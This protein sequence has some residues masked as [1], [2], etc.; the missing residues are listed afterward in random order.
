M[1][2]KVPHVLIQG[3]F[4]LLYVVSCSDPDPSSSSS[5]SSYLS[6]DPS[7]IPKSELNNPFLLDPNQP[8]NPFALTNPTIDFSTES[9]WG[10]NNSPPAREENNS[11][12]AGEENNEIEKVEIPIESEPSI[13]QVDSATL[14]QRILSLELGYHVN[15]NQML[16]EGLGYGLLYDSGNIHFLVKMCLKKV[17]IF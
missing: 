12:P 14:T 6:H 17:Y 13:D 7:I 5:S 9:L 2:L 1:L 11:P 15:S 16:R 3:A 10:E 4:Y 8:S